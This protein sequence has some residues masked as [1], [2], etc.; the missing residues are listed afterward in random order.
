LRQRGQLVSGKNRRIIS[1]GPFAKS[2]EAIGKPATG[3]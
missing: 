2:K 1:D 3:L